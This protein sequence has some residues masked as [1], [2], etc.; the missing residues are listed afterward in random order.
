MYALPRSVVCDALDSTRYDYVVSPRF[1][2]AVWMLAT[3]VMKASFSVVVEYNPDVPVFMPVVVT[4]V[5]PV[6]CAT[7]VAPKKP[8][9]SVLA[10]PI[11]TPS[12]LLLNPCCFMLPLSLFGAVM[13]HPP[14]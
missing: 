2:R 9:T 3:A 13:S 8:T 10:L 5:F 7:G 1:F 11:T 4:V 12:G 6:C 14:S